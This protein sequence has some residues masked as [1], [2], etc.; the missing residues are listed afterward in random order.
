MDARKS[1]GPEKVK[2]IAASLKKN[3]TTTSAEAREAEITKQQKRS[4][5]NAI[6]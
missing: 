2:A 4:K 1:L 3:D 5:D 6:Y